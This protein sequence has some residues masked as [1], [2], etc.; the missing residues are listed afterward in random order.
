M[1]VEIIDNVTKR[2]RVGGLVNVSAPYYIALYA[3]KKEKRDLHGAYIIVFKYK[4]HWMLLF[5][6]GKKKR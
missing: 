2:G 1:K 4:G 5:G 3:E 6:H